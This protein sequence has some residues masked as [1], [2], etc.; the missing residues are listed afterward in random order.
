MIRI[1]Q[2][3]IGIYDSEQAYMMGLMDYI[4]SDMGS[5][6]Y[7]VAF[8]TVEKLI[9]YLNI[10]SLDILVMP[11]DI[12]DK[13]LITKFADIKRIFLTRDKVEKVKNTADCSYLFKYVRAGLISETAISMLG[14]E[15]TIQTNRLYRTYAVISPVGRCGKTRFAK[16]VCASDDVRGG[17]YIGME[18]YSGENACQDR[19]D[20]SSN[21][22]YLV[23]NRDSEIINYITENIVVEENIH[24]I[25]SPCSYLD[26]NHICL[27]D[28]SWLI[29]K[30]VEWGRYTTMVFDIGAA[31]LRD[32]SCLEAF[33]YIIMPVLPDESSQNKREAFYAMLKA[34][35]LCK[36][37]GRIR[38]IHLPDAD[39]KSS[40]MIRAVE[41]VIE[42]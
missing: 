3:K 22:F 29:E 37:M 34:N 17:L 39:F 11:E 33:D 9:E 15:K 25:P 32:I 38:E 28:I 12:A 4:N 40:T 31:V 42:D 13:T 1:R 10:K 8:T 5:P 26:M 19:E 16:A 14:I 23:K 30:L 36:L 21:M 20:I 35:E 18:A 2:Y 7:A 6:L 41:E 27:A 24:C